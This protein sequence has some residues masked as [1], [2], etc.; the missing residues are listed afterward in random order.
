MQPGQQKVLGLPS[1]GSRL[2][3]LPQQHLLPRLSS[4]GPGSPSHPSQSH[5]ALSSTHHPLSPPPPQTPCL[6]AALQSHLENP[7]QSRGVRGPG[8]FS[9]YKVKLPLSGSVCLYGYLGHTV[10]PVQPHIDIHV[11]TDLPESQSSPLQN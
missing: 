9:G 4:V 1:A 7:T 5:L 2:C 3:P 10:C 6:G 8:A 11:G